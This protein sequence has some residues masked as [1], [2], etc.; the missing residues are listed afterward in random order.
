MIECPNC[1][2]SLPDWAKACQFCQTDTAQVVRPKQDVPNARTFGPPAWIW[3]AYY[4]VSSLILI[5]A[6][7]NIGVT[8]SHSQKY[9]VDMIGWIVIVYNSVSA[10]MG[11]GL[12]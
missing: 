4:A 5:D 2:A 12:L 10:L 7:S 3:A 11:I 6:L 8:L 9:G 1:K